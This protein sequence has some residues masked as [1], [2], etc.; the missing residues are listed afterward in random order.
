MK[1]RDKRLIAATNPTAWERFYWQLN[2][3]L[4]GGFRGRVSI[5]TTNWKAQHYK[6]FAMFLRP[7]R[8]GS[9]I[10]DKPI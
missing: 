7:L 1:R 5:T 10:K 4:A 6:S 9:E 2:D 3:D 8:L